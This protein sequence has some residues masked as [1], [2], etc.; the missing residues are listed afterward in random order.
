MTSQTS[1]LRCRSPISR[2]SWHPLGASAAAQLLRLRH[3]IFL[4]A[5]GASIN[6]SPG[7][8]WVFDFFWGVKGLGLV[9]SPQ[10]CVG[11]LFLILYP[12]LL[13]PGLLLLPPPPSHIQHTHTSPFAVANTA[14]RVIDLQFRCSR[15]PP[16]ALGYF[17]RWHGGRSGL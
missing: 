10:L 1:P 7:S 3:G 11:F 16:P 9:F 15:C 6:I 13:P 17:F 2:R 4:G 5:G 12:G 8:P 14:L